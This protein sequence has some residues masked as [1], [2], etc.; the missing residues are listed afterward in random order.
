[1]P[2]LMAELIATMDIAAA[3]AYW[4]TQ[5]ESLR[6]G[7]AESLPRGGS[8]GE[9]GIW[10]HLRGRRIRWCV[11]LPSPPLPAASAFVRPLAFVGFPDAGCLG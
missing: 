3:Y 10:V 7:W 6:V 5:P 2:V 8:R 9:G 1:M 4:N 11:G